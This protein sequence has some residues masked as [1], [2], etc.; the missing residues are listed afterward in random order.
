MDTELRM[1]AGSWH[2]VVMNDTLV[3]GFEKQAVVDRNFFNNCIFLASFKA[4][5]LY[6][7]DKNPGEWFD[8]YVGVLW[9]YG[10]SFDEEPVEFVQ[11]QFSGSVQQAWMMSAARLVT[12]SQLA[13]VEAA[14]AALEKDA[15]LLA[16]FAGSSVKTHKSHIVPVRYGANGELV[17]VLSQ[18]RFIKSVMRTTYLFWQIHQPMSQLDI[19]ARRLVINRR[20][21]DANR[22][23]LALAIRDIPFKL[24][25]HEL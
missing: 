4:N 15:L 8:Y 19:R 14:H 21:M 12:R 17:V 16:K 3:T 23:R 13:Q 7:S 5:K 25:E 22:E 18:I 1:E 20:A 6:D 11:P 24:E 9:S 10:W 2:A